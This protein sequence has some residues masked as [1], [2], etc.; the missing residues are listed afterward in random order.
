MKIIL[1]NSYEQIKLTFLMADFLVFFVSYPSTESEKN[2]IPQYFFKK[3]SYSSKLDSTPIPVILNDSSLSR[4]D[5]MLNEGVCMH[6][7]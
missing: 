2:F 3:N 6:P 7:S 5:C 1:F 4:V